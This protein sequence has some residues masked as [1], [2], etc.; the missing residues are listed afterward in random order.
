MARQK[1][2]FTEALTVRVPPEVRKEIEK[3]TDGGRRS[4]NQI[5]NDLLAEALGLPLAATNAEAPAR[6]RKAARS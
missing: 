2:P 6:A 5:V 1:G 3:R 4:F